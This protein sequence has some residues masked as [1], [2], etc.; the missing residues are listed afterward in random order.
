V[1]S[2]QSK[3]NCQA[4]GD[5]QHHDQGD[6]LFIDLVFTFFMPLIHNSSFNSAYS[7]ANCNCNYPLSG[8]QLAVLAG[9]LTAAT[10]FAHHAFTAAKATGW[11]AASTLRAFSGR[12]TNRRFSNNWAGWDLS[13]GFFFFSHDGLLW[14]S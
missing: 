12:G 5:C 14:I 2:N 7:S 6:N 1:S 9:Y 4:G 8:R 10:G 11:L 13:S 3:Q